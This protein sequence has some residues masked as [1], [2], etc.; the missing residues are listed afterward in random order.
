MLVNK[1]NEKVLVAV[2]YC[3]KNCKR[4]YPHT[5]TL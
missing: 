4:F 3:D 2:D 5:A 1:C